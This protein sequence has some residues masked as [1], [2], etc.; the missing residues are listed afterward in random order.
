MAKIIRSNPL[1]TQKL[2]VAD[3]FELFLRSRNSLCA[4]STVAIYREIGE[5]H[6]IPKIISLT[7]DNI[8]NITEPVVRSILDEYA[9]N[10]T[11]GGTDY[12]FRHLKAFINW[13]W[14]EYEMPRRNP[15]KK[16]RVKKASAPP[17]QGITR[18][19]VDKLLK[20]AKT[21]SLFPERDIAM[22][23]ILCD[24]GIRRA[25]LCGLRMKDVNN[26]KAEMTVFEKDQQYHVKAYGNATSK[27][28]KKYLTCLYDIK[29]EDPFWLCLDGTAF[30]W[31]GMRSVL[32][33]L[34]QA[35]GIP[36]HHFH[37]FRRFYALELYDSTH[38]IYLVSRALDHKDIGI[39][40]RYL[41]VDEK[42]DMEM[43]RLHSPMDK[44]FD[45]TGVK[46]QR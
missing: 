23:M 24:T 36:M 30:D 38:D 31:S 44:K 33:R 25:S 15:M 32:R 20:A 3:V 27:A 29:P 45:Q 28:I 39:T 9:A 26:T 16:I 19:E 1:T 40:K 4:K 7:G 2:G 46:V 18:D 12:L 37:D 5:R 17:K 22:I 35:A 6:I 41:R 11:V 21:H 43:A 14:E 34:C 13:L 8:Y 42:Q 10:H